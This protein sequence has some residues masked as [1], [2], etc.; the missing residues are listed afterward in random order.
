[1]GTDHQWWEKWK[2]NGLITV[3]GCMLALFPLPEYLPGMVGT[4][5]AL[6][7]VAWSKGPGG[8]GGMGGIALHQPTRLLEDCGSR[9]ESFL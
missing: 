3:D 2:H 4:V 7:K 8:L 5:G 6:N 1:M 9:K